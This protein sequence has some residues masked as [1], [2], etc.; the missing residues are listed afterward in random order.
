MLV[1]EWTARSIKK[2]L[3]AQHSLDDF[4]FGPYFFVI[5]QIGEIN[6]STKFIDTSNCP[7][8]LTLSFDRPEHIIQSVSFL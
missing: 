4:L 6:D 2:M 3:V 7:S 8:R 1:S 5:N